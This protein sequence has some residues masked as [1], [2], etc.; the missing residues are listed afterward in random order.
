MSIALMGGV[1]LRV[2]NYTTPRFS[3]DEY[4]DK[5]VC[6]GFVLIF[7]SGFAAGTRLIE[8][9]FVSILERIVRIPITGA[10]FIAIR[11]KFER[12]K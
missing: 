4:S 2:V 9:A 10:A 6:L 1:L 5:L 11:R 3:P 7:T 12:K 8:D